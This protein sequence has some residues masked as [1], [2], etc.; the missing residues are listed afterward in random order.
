MS[1]EREHDQL[2]DTGPVTHE[3]IDGDVLIV[4]AGIAG[5][6]SALDLADGG[7][8]VVL[9][10]KEPGIGGKMAA[11]DKNFPTLDCSIC[12]E[13]PKMSD[14]I[15]HDNIQVLTLANVTDLYGDVGDF[16]AEVYQQPRFV[17]DECT[18]CDDCVEACPETTTNEFDEG[19]ATRTAIYTPFEQAEPGPYV[20]DLETC[21][22]EP[23]NYMPCDRCQEACK[24]DCIDF[25][26]TPT[27][28]DVNV[29][30]VIAATGFDVL[31]PQVVEEYGYGDHP[32]VVTSM[33]YERLLDAAGPTEGHIVKPSDGE[34][35]DN[36]LFVL[37]V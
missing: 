29:S 8:E 35:P 33:E 19:M 28:Y 2:T 31:N 26:M 37:C 9:V 17:G 27:R 21:M 3:T 13:A 11:L 20:L 25:S 36:I 7:I 30:S 23:P 15:Q 1:T 10:E 12:I 34:E 32:D 14:V 16:T 24:P 22:N 6:Q 18:R 4:G 5:I